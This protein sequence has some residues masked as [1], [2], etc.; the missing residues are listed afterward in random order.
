[1]IGW[2]RHNLIEARFSPFA[3]D[4]MPFRKLKS[5]ERQHGDFAGARRCIGC[6]PIWHIRFRS[7]FRAGSCAQRAS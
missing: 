1:M 4:L 2:D 5:A 3:L 6:K 7:A